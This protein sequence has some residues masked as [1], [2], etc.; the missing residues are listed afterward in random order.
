MKKNNMRS[1]RKKDHAT[2]DEAI[3]CGLA[4]D[5]GLY[6]PEQFPKIPIEEFYGYSDLIDF[7]LHLLRPFFGNSVLNIDYEFCKDVFS[8]PLPLKALTETH[9]VL[10][11]FHGPT[12]SFKDFGARF[13]AQCLQYLSQNKPTKVLVAT[14]G[15]TGS[16]VAS[17]LHGRSGIEGYILFPKDKISLRQQAQITCWGDNIHAL[18]VKGTFDQCQQLVKM[19]CLKYE[20]KGELTTANSIN[21]ARLLPQ[22]VYYAYSSI[23]LAKRHQKSVN[24]IVPSG[25]LGNVTACYWAKFLGFPI[26]EILIA[27]NANRVLTDYLTSGTYKAKPSIKTLANAMDVGDPSNLERLMDLFGDFN[28]FKKSI[29][30]QS[31]LDNEIIQAIVDCYNRHQYILCPHTATSYY[32]LNEVDSSKIWVLAGTAHPVKFNELI[33]PLLN[34]SIPVPAQLK[35][36]LEKKHCF[37]EIQFGFESF[38]EILNQ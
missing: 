25:N 38:C 30:V 4:R 24:Y 29:N 11:L 37:N 14:S 27:N 19:A 12:L 32:R 5:G 17:A 1:T 15:D 26:D 9:Y 8:F 13:F 10:E 28:Q 31:V 22:I 18:A 23:N 7:S 34:I 6:V 16:A 36:M 3:L 21:I 20:F 33:E 35:S 2:I